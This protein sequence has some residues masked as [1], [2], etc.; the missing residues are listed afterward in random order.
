MQP[1]THDRRV[2]SRTG[3]VVALVGQRGQAQQDSCGMQR[4]EEAG[5]SGGSQVMGLRAT[6]YLESRL[7]REML[8]KYP[9][10]ADFMTS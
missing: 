6:N 3:A 2:D 5:G 4:A 7:K 10:I 1:A 8:L 9:E